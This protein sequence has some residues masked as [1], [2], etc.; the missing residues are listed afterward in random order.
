M[1]AEMI[2]SVDSELAKMIGGCCKMS[3]STYVASCEKTGGDVSPEVG[4]GIP[5][6][7]SSW[8]FSVGLPIAAVSCVPPGYVLLL[9]VYQGE[10]KSGFP[11]AQEL[12]PPALE[13]GSIR[14]IPL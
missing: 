4:G 8:I 12:P 10:E 11:A 1:A 14:C 7:G 3:E 5:A 9:W 2:A 6:G 13:F